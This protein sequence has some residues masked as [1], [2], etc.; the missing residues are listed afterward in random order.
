MK[1][2]ELVELILNNF[3]GAEY[4]NLTTNGLNLNILGNNGTGKTR[5]FDAFIWLLFGRDS[6]N[7]T[8]FDIKT[9]DEN[10]N[11]KEHELDH[12]VEGIFDIDG[13]T[14]SLKRVYAEKWTKKQKTRE[15]VMSG[16]TT[17]YYVNEVPKSAKE[18]EDFI[19]TIISDKAFKML[20]NPLYFNESLEWK[21][22]RNILLEIVGG[23]TDEEVIR[24]SRDK[25]M[26]DFLER[27]GERTIEDHK[28]V[29]NEKR[30]ELNKKLD[31]IP[32]RIDE[33]NLAIPDPGE[34]NKEK[35]EGDLES[36]ENDTA[37]YRKK[38]HEIL[39]GTEI[40]NKKKE[41]GNIEL[42]ISMMEN[43]TKQAGMNEQY[44]IKA[45]IQES[46]SNVEILKSKMDYHIQ[47][48]EANNGHIENYMKKVNL[49]R[50]D[51]K[52]KA[53]EKLEH[54]VACECPTCNQTLPEEQIEAAKKK[55]EENFNKEK[56][57]KLEE[58][59]KAGEGLK[60]DIESL[61][62]KNAA[63]YR[64]N[65]E[66]EK[67][68][69]RTENKINKLTEELGELENNKSE[70]VDNPKLIENQKRKEELKEEIAI[71]EKSVMD[72]AREYENKV[73]ELELKR[74]HLVSDL[75]AFQGMDKQLER[76][77]ELEE[78]E[79]SLSIELENVERELYLIEE[80]T[81][82]KVKLLEKKINDKFEVTKFRLFKEKVSG[83]YEETCVALSN[84]VPFNSGL[85]SAKRVNVGLDIINTLQEYYGIVAP[86][87]ID[88]A[89]SVTELIDTDAQIIRMVVSK[90]DKALKINTDE[91]AKTA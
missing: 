6:L 83:G 81:T 30:V 78:Q 41:L 4:F 74:N 20:T 59:Q 10:G 89:E 11:V 75:A 64:K 35:I 86:I 27:L 24:S 15:R 21:E 5:L 68:I 22:R 37:F 85:N 33:I 23:V 79:R 16:H 3:K 88:N 14:V 76:I 80:F 71:L 2:I 54:E 31:M 47:M 58:I 13:K 7:R 39:S 72:S 17:K 90:E 63:L 1:R 19:Q 87:F 43:E 36:V 8:N 65:D 44:K 70:K 34:G 46:A 91:A 12:S 29:M 61:K 40:S 32:I 60:N 82:K 28:K 56:S 50:D 57:L 49:F 26:N 51:W 73:N 53:A 52:V 67:E 18:Y 84:G 66:L 55:A 62:E 42:E 45:S 25:D 38:I 77:A 48:I 69:M 9:L